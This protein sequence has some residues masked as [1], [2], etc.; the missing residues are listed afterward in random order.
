MFVTE[1]VYP[2]HMA[3]HLKLYYS[4]VM[5]SSL[6]LQIWLT[7]IDYNLVVTLLNGAYCPIQWEVNEVYLNLNRDE[8]DLLIMISE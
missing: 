4:T 1:K 3:E 7:V 5:T 6:V 2:I 8:E